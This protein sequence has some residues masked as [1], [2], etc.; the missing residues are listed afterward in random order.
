MRKDRR[1]YSRLYYAEHKEELAQKRLERRIAYYKAHPRKAQKRVP[2]ELRM[3]VKLAHK[4]T[5]RAI[6]RLIYAA[7][8]EKNIVTVAIAADNGLSGPAL[9]N[10]LSDTACGC[11]HVSE[12]FALCKALEIDPKEIYENARSQAEDGGEEHA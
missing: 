2:H 9:L 7:M 8:K 4:R 10:K 12:F 3:D 6:G 5:D 1:E 11:L